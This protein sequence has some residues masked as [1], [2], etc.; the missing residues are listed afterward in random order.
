MAPRFNA[1]TR[2]AFGGAGAKST[3][4][5]AQ[6]YCAGLRLS[7]D[8]LTKSP[9]MREALSVLGGGEWGLLQMYANGWRARRSRTSRCVK[10]ASGDRVPV[11]ARIPTAADTCPNGRL[12][13]AH[14]YCWL[15][16]YGCA[17][18][19]I[20]CADAKGRMLRRSCRPPSAV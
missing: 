17:P 15:N 19:R 8:A 9:M 10:C 12:H 16:A 2:E 1:A 3:R 4:A 6:L 7:S 11:G 14:R 18:R 13:S 20:T 5:Q